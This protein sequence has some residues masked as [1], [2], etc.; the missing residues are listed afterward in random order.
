M[1]EK[2]ENLTTENSAAAGTVTAAIAVPDLKSMTL[3]ELTGTMKEKGYPAFRARQLYRWMHVSLARE[4][5]EMTN[6]PKA[7]AEELKR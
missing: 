3:E 6:S 5:G 2:S 1:Q 4:Y 7:M